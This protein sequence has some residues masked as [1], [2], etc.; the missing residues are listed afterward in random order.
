SRKTG[1]HQQCRTLPGKTIHDGEDANAAACLNRIGHEVDGPLLIRPAQMCRQLRHPGDSLSLKPSCHQ[2]FF[3][4]QPMNA[5][6]VYLPAP[7]RQNRP[8]PPIAVALLLV[9]QCNQNRAQIL[10]AIRN[11]FVPVTSAGHFQKPA[12]LTFAQP[13]FGHDE[14]HVA[15]RTHKLQPFFL[16]TVVSA[17]LSRLRSA[18]ISFSRRFSSSSARSFFTSLT[19]I[20]PYFAFQLY[21]VWSLTPSSRATSFVVRPPSICLTAATIFS[22]VYFVFFISK[23]SFFITSFPNYEWFSFPGSGQTNGDI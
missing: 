11:C 12:S 7:P 14:R 9:R 5:L 13:V 6:Q 21:S 16:M 1:V 18:T 8:Q 4:V 20:P 23:S 3:P 17:A 15:P 19:S 10:I 2:L 22:S